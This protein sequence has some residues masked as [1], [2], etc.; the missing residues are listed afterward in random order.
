MIRRMS[1][2]V[3]NLILTKEAGEDNSDE[4]RG[5][6]PESVS[7]GASF[8]VLQVQLVEIQSE[9]VSLKTCLQAQNAEHQL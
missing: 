4:D 7:D 6:D 9:L 1:T 3:V 2:I 8:S 5:S